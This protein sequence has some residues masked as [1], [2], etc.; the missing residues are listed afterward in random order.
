MDSASWGS[1]RIPAG[2]C[3]VGYVTILVAR[4][5]VHW[6]C[7]LRATPANGSDW[8][9]RFCWCSI[10]RFDRIA[11]LLFLRRFFFLVV[12]VVGSDIS[13]PS[14]TYTDEPTRQI[15]PAYQRS[16]AKS[17]FWSPIPGKK[18]KLAVK[19][20][21]RPFTAVNLVRHAPW[22]SP[23]NRPRRTDQ[24]VPGL[25]GRS[26]QGIGLGPGGPG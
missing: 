24:R 20:H 3:R 22:A 5:P 26:R 15:P 8:G 16:T 18:T 11:L 23:T 2:G 19:P 10:D 1:I 14:R 4:Q 12:C 13:D 25:C 21:F 6:V 7:C 9:A 17:I